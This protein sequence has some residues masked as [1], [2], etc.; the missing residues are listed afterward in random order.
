[1]R[2]IR[3]EHYKWV[4]AFIFVLLAILSYTLAYDYYLNSAFIKSAIIYLDKKADVILGLTGASTSASVA[5]T[6]IPGDVGTPIAGKLADISS[7]SIIILAAVHLEKYLITIAAE[8]ALRCVVPGTMIFAAVNTTLFE[9]VQLRSLIKKLCTFALALI[10]V[11][12]ASVRLS[13]LIEKTYEDDVQMS[14]EETQRE[15]DEIKN[16][17]VG[18]DQSIIK[19]FWGVVAGKTTETVKKFENSLNNFVEAIAVM[20]ITACVIP[21]ITFAMLIWLIKSV[22]QVDFQT[23]SLASLASKTKLDP[24]KVKEIYHGRKQDN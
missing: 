17:L 12:P 19:K 4:W 14:I 8:I 16:N 7:Y 15:A 20:I 2:F 23:P 6:L 3:E 1:M 10:L 21:L 5:M 18:Q 11:V 13:T 9:N 22:L 24:N